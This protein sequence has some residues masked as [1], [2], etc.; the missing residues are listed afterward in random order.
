[1]LYI[2]FTIL[3]YK[4]WKKFERLANNHKSTC[5]QVEIY[6]FVRMYCRAETAI[7]VLNFA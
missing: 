7:V 1:M 3:M 5:L 4:M 2:V 6:V